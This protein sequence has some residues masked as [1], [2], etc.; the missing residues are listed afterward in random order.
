M[1]TRLSNKLD[2]NK[3]NNIDNEDNSFNDNNINIK[4]NYFKDIKF[5]KDEKN[6]KYLKK[7]LDKFTNGEYSNLEEKDNNLLN[8]KEQIEKVSQKINKELE[9]IK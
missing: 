2:N 7:F 6:E 1:V 8:L 9:S 3:E 5:V 4:Y